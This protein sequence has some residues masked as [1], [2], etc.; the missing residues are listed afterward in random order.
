MS[1]GGGASKA[2]AQAVE[3]AG[4]YSADATKYASDVASST[5]DKQMAQQQGF[6]DTQRADTTTQR[7]LGQQSIGQLISGMSDG[8]LTKKFDGGD[9]ASDPGYQFRMQQGQ[10]ALTGSALAG[11][12]LQSGA[13]IKAMDQ[14]NQGFASNEY[15]NAYNRYTNDQNNTFQ[16]LM[17]SAGLG[18]AAVSTGGQQVD[19]MTNIT[20]QLGNTLGS[21]A[22]ANASNQANLQMQLGNINAGP[23]QGQRALGGAASGAMAGASMGP[24]G[25]LAGGVIGGLGALF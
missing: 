24:W 20:G 2:Q 22:T 4:K 12:G 13:Y 5:A 17:G 18:Q 6:Y 14:Y 1:G 7:Q 21:L 8:S 19:N 10:G 15:N 11:S 16:K 25:A 23:S 3:K 9:L